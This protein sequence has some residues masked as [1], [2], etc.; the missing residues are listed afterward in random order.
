MFH[1]GVV[2][3]ELDAP[4]HARAASPGV[5][6]GEFGQN[7]NGAFVDIL[8]ATHSIGADWTHSFNDTGTSSATAFDRERSTS[9]AARFLIVFP[10]ASLHVLRGSSSSVR[11]MTWDSARIR[12]SHRAAP[13]RSPRF[14]RLVLSNKK[15]P[16]GTVAY[17]NPFAGAD[18]GTPT[19]GT[20]EYV[21]YGSDGFDSNGNYQPGTP[22]DPASALNQ[23]YLQPGI[24]TRAGS[25]ISS[26]S[27]MTAVVKN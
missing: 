1:A 17:L 20:P 13:S 16:I 9:R 25:P 5:G 10:Q 6:G 19:P 2:R 3:T 22:V 12:S 24:G 26:T 18:T 7:A 14:C 27:A 23:M 4:S 21:V 11:T 15:A 8:A